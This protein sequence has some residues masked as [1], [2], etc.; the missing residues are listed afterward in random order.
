MNVLARIRAGGREIECG[1]ATTSEERAAVQAQ[2]FRVYQRRGYYQA[3]LQ[4]D[5]DAY[6]QTAD[7]FLTVLPIRDRG[8]VL[9]GSARLIRGEPRAGFTFPA[10]QAFAFELP[11]EVAK[12]AVAERVEV[13]RVV[14]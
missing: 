14:A 6:D 1:L 8:A 9:L 7:S 4:T 5:R 11:D 13:T 10:E 12:T 2:R 3:G